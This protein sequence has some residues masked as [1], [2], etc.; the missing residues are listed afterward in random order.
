MQP[1]TT[2]RPIDPAAVQLDNGAKSVWLQGGG[3][4]QFTGSVQFAKHTM[5]PL[6]L[7]WG[8]EN[9]IGSVYQT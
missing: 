1:N 8:S 5:Y 4:V 6:N 3:S 9:S 7:F 2:G